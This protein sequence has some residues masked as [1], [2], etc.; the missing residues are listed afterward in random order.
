MVLSIFLCTIMPV[1]ASVFT[2]LQADKLY[3]SYIQ[4]MFDNGIVMGT[5][6]NTLA[7]D[8][9]CTRGQFVTFLWRAS[10]MADAGSDGSA[11]KDLPKDSYYADAAMWAYENGICK[12]YSDGSFDGEA[13]ADREH[14]AYFLYNWAKLIGKCKANTGVLLTPYTDSTE[15]S[16][17]SVT[18]FAW[19]ISKELLFADENNM[20]NPKA[21]VTRGEV[22]YAI[23]KI[24]N[25]HI[26][27]WSDFADNGDGTCTR[28]C[29]DDSTHTQ[30]SEHKWNDGELTK[31][32]IKTKKGEITYTCENCRLSKTEKVNDT[33]KIVTRAQLEEAV[34]SN[35]KRSSLNLSNSQA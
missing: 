23:G 3:A 12:I 2:D 32:D 24:L 19:A 27:N 29:A 18:A 1:Q 11:I 15:I 30:T 31:S 8:E 10:Q 16:K 34:L 9:I 22:I 13:I 21:P 28:V 26:C 6:S 7:P 20:L 5:S 17:D 35:L 25:E 14:A 4:Q 33:S